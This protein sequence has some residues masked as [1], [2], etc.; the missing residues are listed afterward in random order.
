LYEPR[1]AALLA[2]SH[3]EKPPFFDPLFKPH[4]YYFALSFFS[5][6]SDVLLAAKILEHVWKGNTEW[7]LFIRGI[8]SGYGHAPLK[9]GYIVRKSNT[10]Y[11]EWDLINDGKT[12]VLISQRGIEDFGQ[13][14]LSI[15]SGMTFKHPQWRPKFI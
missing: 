3:L 8:V 10:N 15:W 5:C 14:I 7:A 1:I 6:K 13:T 12:T 9:K 4:Q 2:K 11:D